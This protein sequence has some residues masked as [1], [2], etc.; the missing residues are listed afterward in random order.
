[1]YYC[2]IIWN[3]INYN[4]MKNNI[5]LT[6]KIFTPSGLYCIINS[7][8][9]INQP[10]LSIKITFVYPQNNNIEIKMLDLYNV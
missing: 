6:L 10:T 3:K 8:L 7:Y 9:L 4:L 1:M 2:Y 5:L